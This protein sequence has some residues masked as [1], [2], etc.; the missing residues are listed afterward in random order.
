MSEVSIGGGV[1][2]LQMKSEVLGFF[3]TLTLVIGQKQTKL[4]DIWP[5]WSFDIAIV[6]DYQIFRLGVERFW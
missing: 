2:K 5:N 6:S 4:D 1:S 3:K